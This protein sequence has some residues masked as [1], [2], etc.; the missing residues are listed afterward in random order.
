MIRIVIAEI[1]LAALYERFTRVKLKFGLQCAHQTRPHGKTCVLPYR[2][3]LIAH[4]QILVRVRKRE[5]KCIMRF[6]N[7]MAQRIL[8]FVL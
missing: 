6:S 2:P 5:I 1:T 8:F 4:F 3:Q 7:H